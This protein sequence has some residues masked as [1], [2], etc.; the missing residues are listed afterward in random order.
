[1]TKMRR[2][3]EITRR[4]PPA[5]LRRGIAEMCKQLNIEHG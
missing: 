4:L 3:T 1:M 2:L 5:E